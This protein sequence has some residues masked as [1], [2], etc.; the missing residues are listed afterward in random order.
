MLEEVQSQELHQISQG[1]LVSAD[2][3]RRL[4]E[5]ATSVEE[6]ILVVHPSGGNASSAD[7][8]VKCT[9]RARLLECPLPLHVLIPAEVAGTSVSSSD[10]SLPFQKYFF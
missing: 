9:P 2:I 6:C 1:R 8:V 10:K 7:L 3:F 5:K 4:L